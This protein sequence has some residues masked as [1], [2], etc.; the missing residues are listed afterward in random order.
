MEKSKIRFLQTGDWHLGQNWPLLPV[1][2]A[3]RFK[4]RQAD[5]FHFL[6]DACKE[7]QIDLVILTGDIFDQIQPDKKNLSAFFNMTEEIAKPIVVAP[8]NH[9]PILPGG[10]WLNEKWPAHVHILSRDKHIIEL[11]E[12]EAVISG[13]PF[14]HQLA[15]RPTHFSA[16]PPDDGSAFHIAVAHGDL[17]DRKSPFR[18]LYPDFI[19]STNADYF[20]AG[21]NH[22]MII[23]EAVEVPYASAGSPLG[24]S[25]ADP[26]SNAFLIG[27]LTGELLKN[28]RA[29]LDLVTMK[30]MQK[31]KRS[32]VKLRAYPLYLPKFISWEYSCSYEDTNADIVQAIRDLFEEHLI[33]SHRD[34]LWQI[35]L[36]G[37]RSPAVDFRLIEE[38]FQRD[39][40]YFELKDMRQASSFPDRGQRLIFPSFTLKGNKMAKVDDTNRAR[41]ML[42]QNLA[43]DYLF[44]A[45][46]SLFGTAEKDDFNLKR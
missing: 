7:S 19:R 28:S 22:E 21:H 17:I 26:G 11:Q 29:N 14:E 31:Q 27:E 40:L 42:L 33:S 12:I 23:K 38:Y 6:I 18:P 43:V 41:E 9:D 24:R 46:A 30:Q 44:N 16:F 13:L 25:F 36:T 8:G 4:T 5:L 39:Y 37:D 20:A 32:T 45:A 15:A 2:I 1:E 3:Q 10:S 34:D 35:K